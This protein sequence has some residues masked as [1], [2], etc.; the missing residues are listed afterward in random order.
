MASLN[1]QAELLNQIIRGANSTVFDLL[2]EKGRTI[3]FPHQGILGQTKEAKDKKLNATIGMAYEDD[4]TIMA[5]TALKDKISLDKNSIFPYA[6]S[7]GNQNLREVWQKQILKKNPSLNK[8]NLSLPVVTNAVTHG[9]SIV[10]YLFADPETEIIIAEPAWDNYEL[11]FNITYGARISYFPLFKNNGFNRGGLKEK[12]N[13]GSLKKILLLNFPNNPTGYT[14]S[15]KE[16]DQIVEIINDFGKSHKLIVVCDDAYFGLVY[17]KGIFKESIFS[18][19]CHISPNVLAIK[20]DGVTKEDYAWGLRIGFVTLGLKNRDR[21]F[22]SA[23]EDKLAGAIRATIS[24][25][26]NFSQSLILQAF[27]ANDYEEEKKEKRKILQERY[28]TVKNILGKNQQYKKYFKALP[29]NSG[30]FMCLKL[31]DTLKAEQVRLHL[32][33]QYDTGLIV[34]DNFLRVAFSS[35]AK[36]KLGELFNNIYSA[37]QNIKN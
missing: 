20:V 31:A 29:Y 32:L 30:Y 2:S 28:E 19:L 23:L 4:G 34:V 17:E 22:Y 12:L 25:A 7:F 1:K 11:I 21:K 16:V 27:L 13:R 24:N 3:Y 18:K 10:G 36:E 37:C 26:S 14:P 33:E 8:N 15:E 9:L 35:L 6:S 5:L